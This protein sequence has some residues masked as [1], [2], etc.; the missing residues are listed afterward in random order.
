MTAVTAKAG[1]AASAAADSGAWLCL[2]PYAVGQVVEAT[3]RA[4]SLSS[5]YQSSSDIVASI[6][7]SAEAKNESMLRSIIRQM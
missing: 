4:S 3:G 2:G 7:T 5:V 1:A 6:P